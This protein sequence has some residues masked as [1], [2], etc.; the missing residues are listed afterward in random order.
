M[1]KICWSPKGA[2]HGDKG[3]ADAHDNGKL[4]SNPPDGI[5]LN[6]GGDSRHKHCV[7][8]QNGCLGLAQGR[9]GSAC[10]DGNRRKVGDEHGQDVLE[11]EGDGLGDGHP[12]LQSVYV[13][14]AAIRISV[15]N[16][17]PLL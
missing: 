17:F 3:K 16:W 1:A 9:L 4:R 7:L 10:Y 13:V 2:E 12:A 14:D 5:Q 8:K 11:A 6:H 15:H